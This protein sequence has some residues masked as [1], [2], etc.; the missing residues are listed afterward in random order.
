[1]KLSESIIEIHSIFKA[2]TSQKDADIFIK[3]L[4]SNIIS[5]LLEEGRFNSFELERA[6]K[7]ELQDLKRMSSTSAA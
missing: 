5:E 4:V 1:M 7:K 3:A 6:V 2:K